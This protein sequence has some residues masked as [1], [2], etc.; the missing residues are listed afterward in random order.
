MSVYATQYG[1]WSID[2]KYDA[3]TVTT[4]YFGWRFVAMLVSWLTYW[5]N[6]AFWC[7]V[8]LLVG[9]LSLRALCGCVT[10]YPDKTIDQ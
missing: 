2:S 6:S 5:N 4:G 8:S 10:Y 1:T 7:A 9:P 3:M